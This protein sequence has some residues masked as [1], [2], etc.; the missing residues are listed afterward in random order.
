M[1]LANSPWL[2][3]WR[4]FADETYLDPKSRLKFTC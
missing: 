4:K 3:D 1:S 2:T